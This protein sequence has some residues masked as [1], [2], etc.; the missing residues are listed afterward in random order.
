MLTAADLA[1]IQ[2][3]IDAVPAVGEG[4]ANPVV[5]G[6][7]LVIPAINSPNFVHG[8]AGWTLNRDGSAE[9]SNVII[10]NGQV[11]SGTDLIYSSSPPV[12]GNLAASVS[13]A[14]GTD[15]PGN[16]YLGGITTYAQSGGVFYAVNLSISAAGGS[17]LA[18][19]I[20]TSAAGPYAEAFDL[21]N[22]L[23]VAP[24]AVALLLASARNLSIR[25]SST[26]NTDLPAQI[27][28]NTVPAGGN[29]TLSM[30]NGTALALVA[31]A[32]AVGTPL[33][34]LLYQAAGHAQAASSADGNAYDIE[35]L[36]LFLAADT[37]IPSTS[38]TTL[39]SKGVVAGTYRFEGIVKGVQGPTAI[40]QFVRFSG[41][42]VSF[43]EI[44]IESN[45]VGNTSV[46]D[47]DLTG[48]YPLDHTTPAWGAGTTFY[49]RFK[50]IA[51]FSATGTFAVQGRANSAVN[52]WTAKAASLLDL[53]PVVA[54]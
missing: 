11:I 13:A 19:L 52:T 17:R 42:G 48:A 27:S 46:T 9:F 5:A 49:V 2:A 40:G 37:P 47:S 54:A 16:A 31:L 6:T 53:F 18:F 26:L 3:M 39:M 41:P 28:L 33:A 32:N 14:A 50:G 22:T 43:N 12:L 25:A 45:A 44:F 23:T 24:T 35:R 15:T 8:S 7:Q 29:P 34:P 4:F 51:T 20:A 10:R 30:D 1:Q 38:A 21:I 36:S